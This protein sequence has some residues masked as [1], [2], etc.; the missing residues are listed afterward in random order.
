MRVVVDTN[1]FLSAALK[2]KS[3]PA[4]AVHLATQHGVLLKSAATE[5]Q[6]LPKTLRRVCRSS[7]KQRIT[8]YRL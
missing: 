3:L 2:D 8:T 4:L 1:V 6:L 5:H 7:Q